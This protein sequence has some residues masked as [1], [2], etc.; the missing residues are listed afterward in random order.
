MSDALRVHAFQKTQIIDVFCDFRKQFAD[1]LTAVAVLA[2]LPERL[3]QRSLADFAE[4]AEAN[5][6]KVDGFTVTVNQLWLVVK[7]VNLA[8]TTLHKDE[9][10]AFCPRR[11]HRLFC[12]Q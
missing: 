9:D 2:K 5:S 12:H 6:G 8:G 3:H 1:V 7:A 4:G 10:D 11:Q